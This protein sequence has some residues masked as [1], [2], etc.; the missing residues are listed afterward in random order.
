MLNKNGIDHRMLLVKEALDHRVI[1]SA[2]V[3]ALAVNR[4][5]QAQRPLESATES[6]I[7]CVEP[8]GANALND[9]HVK[10]NQHWTDQAKLVC[11]PYLPGGFLLMTFVLE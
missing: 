5:V 1:N 10:I 7:D 9:I 2:T 3:R 4:N 8:E 6:S 11:H